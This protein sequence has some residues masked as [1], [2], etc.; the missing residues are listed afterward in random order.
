MIDPHVAVV[1]ITH[2]WNTDFAHWFHVYFDPYHAP[3]YEGLVWGNVFAVLPLG[4]LGTIGFF[5]HKWLT[6][7]HEEFDS[8]T[9]HDERGREARKLFDLLDPHTDGGI[10][11]IH[12]HVHI[13]EDKVDEKTPGGVGSVLEAIKL[14]GHG[15]ERP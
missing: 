4:L 2:L 5:F 12:D 8:K 3:W 9:A 13:I 14:L 1:V 10:K 15:S 6:R 11:E 7:E